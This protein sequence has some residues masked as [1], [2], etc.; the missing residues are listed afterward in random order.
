[1][2]VLISGLVW[3]LNEVI[4]INQWVH[5]QAH[6]KPSINVLIVVIVGIKINCFVNVHGTVLMGLLDLPGEINMQ[7]VFGGMTLNIIVS[8]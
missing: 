4:L 5:H 6:S 8:S 1:M 3:G 2:I 7:T